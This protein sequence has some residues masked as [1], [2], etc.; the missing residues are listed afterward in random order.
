MSAPNAEGFA[1]VSALFRY[2]VKSMRGEALDEL[3]LEGSGVRGDRAYG[4]LDVASGTVL[5]AKREGRLLEAS[6]RL[7]DEELVVTLP[8]GREYD[9]GP[10]LDESLARWLARP[11][12]LVEAAQFGAPVFQS[13][14]DFERDDSPLSSWEGVDSSFVDESALHVLSTGDLRR[15]DQERP[16]LSWDVRRFRPNVVLDADVESARA[17]SRGSRLV[18]G[19][20]EFE[21]S[22]G[23][24]RCVMTTRAQP[25]NLS[26]Q[27]DV[28]RHV[29]A[30]HDRKVGVRAR[31][32]RTGRLHVNDLATA[33]VR[34]R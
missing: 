30:Q 33:H 8:D 3:V 15:L 11:V 13:I 6:A 26:R 28:L 18:V 16:D 14:E 21:V 10:A 22:K 27:L 17:W 5:S 23:C 25:E 32:V 9:P 31:V 34:T 7:E 1:R 4:V 12:R 24:T 20:V 2:P 29:T 19:E